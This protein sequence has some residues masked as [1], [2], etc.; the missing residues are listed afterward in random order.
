MM[1]KKE[2]EQEK[3]KYKRPYGTNI[4]FLGMEFLSEA[5]IYIFLKVSTQIQ[6]TL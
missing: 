3:Q 5:S 1:G 4:F 6:H 2:N